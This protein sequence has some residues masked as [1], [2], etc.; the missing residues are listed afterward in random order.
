MV[1]RLLAE[2]G[3][4]IGPAGGKFP[5]SG[6]LFGSAGRAAGDIDE[7]DRQIVAAKGVS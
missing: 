5:D 2:F 4:E 7:Y 6:G 1:L 3:D